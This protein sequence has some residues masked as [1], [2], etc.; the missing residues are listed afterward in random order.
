MRP[1]LETKPKDQCKIDSRDSQ[2]QA[3]RKECM[4]SVC[5]GSLLD[6]PGNIDG[7]QLALNAAATSEHVAT[8]IPLDFRPS[9]AELR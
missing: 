5:S 9:R 4:A 1:R 3:I 8:T 2:L 6:L 7:H